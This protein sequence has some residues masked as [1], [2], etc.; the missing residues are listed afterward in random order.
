MSVVGGRAAATARST[1]AR[2]RT[3]LVQLNSLALGG[4]QINAVDFARAVQPY[5]FRSVLIAPA[6]T[7][8]TS[9]ASL[10][11]V[12]REHGVRLETYDTSTGV[13]TG[14]A[15]SME[16]FAR[17]T[18]SDLVHVY[19]E[20][21]DHRTAFWGPCFVGR[22]PL[23]HTVYE[24]SVSE[25]TYRYTSLIVGTGYLV[26]DL[27]GRP[28]PTTLISPPVDLESDAPDAKLGLSFRRSEGI[29]PQ[30]FLMVIV[31][32]LD[33]VMKGYPTEVAVRAAGRL[34]PDAVLVV[35]GTGDDE[36]RLRGIAD[37]VNARSGREAVRFI[38]ATADPRP[39]YAAADLVLGM[40][41]SA[42]RALAFGR[43]LIVQ[44]ESGTAELFTPEASADLFRRSFWSPEEAEA[45]VERLVALIESIVERP[46]RRHELGRFGRTFAV[47]HFGLPAMAERLAQV[48]EQ[49]L[50]APHA[51]RGWV[52]DLARS[53]RNRAERAIDR[54][55][56]RIRPGGQRPGSSTA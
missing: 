19:G 31:S 52:L 37:D 25:T 54:A 49:A 42:A 24:M 48:Y 10:F 21:G 39:A 6:D 34:R 7:R 35:V 45:P 13:F 56:G 40:G 15:T 18:R 8:P 33:R 3:V 41:G 47:S 30:A 4:T 43:P 14:R 28:G 11:D 26:D 53:T 2:E 29:D 16:R 22:R 20:N 32:R 1:A 27:R 23:V 50:R 36:A 5:G 51:R 12:A 44:G 38:G 17:A 46:E 9:G 55:G